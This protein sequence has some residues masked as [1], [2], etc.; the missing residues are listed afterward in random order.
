M[1]FLLLCVT[2]FADDIC[3]HQM[4]DSEDSFYEL[5]HAFGALLDLIERAN[6]ELNLTKTTITMRMKGNWPGKST[7]SMSCAHK[8]EH[9]SKSQDQMELTRRSNW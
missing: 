4:F 7:A 5:L 8:M 3:S 1:S 2:I 6:L 9:I